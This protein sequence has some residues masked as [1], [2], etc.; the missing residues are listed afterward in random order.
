MANRGRLWTRVKGSVM[1]PVANAAGDR[2]AEAKAEH[3]ART[4]REP[5]GTTLHVVREQVRERHRDTQPVDGSYVPTTGDG[6]R[7]V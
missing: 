2:E 1:R 4:G 5:D 3:E 7:P 6:S